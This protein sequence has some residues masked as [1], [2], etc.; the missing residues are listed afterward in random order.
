MR[1]DAQIKNDVLDEL[2]WQPNIDE[3]EIGV[4]VENGVVTL[5]GTVNSFSKKLAAEK[6][7]KAVRGVRAV[8][9]DIEV[10]YGL[11]YRKTDK[12]IA[13]AAADALKWNNS[14]PEDKISIKVDNGWIYLSGEVQWSYEKEAAKTAVQH[15][16]G[17]RG[18]SN[19]ITLK[20]SV[21]PGDIKERIR[22]ALERSAQIEADNIKVTVDGHKVKLRG[23]VHSLTEKEEARKAAFFAPGVYDVE[24]DLEVI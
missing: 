24:N 4:T 22:K 2:A 13:K 6:A 10:K 17:V 11:E 1:T 23:Q 15:L 20:Q 9:E 7:V 12:E 14:V 5:S 18:V 19:A 16:I 21:E 3:T 8:A